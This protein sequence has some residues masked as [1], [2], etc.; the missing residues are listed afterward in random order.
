MHRKEFFDGLSKRLSLSK[1]QTALVLDN[2][3]EFIT[4][5]LCNDD[6]INFSAFGKFMNVHKPFKLGRSPKT[7][8]PFKIPAKAVPVF[9]PSLALKERIKK[10]VPAK[11]SFSC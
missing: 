8:E 3:F 4:E 9:K 11:N 10:N 7:G 5:V 6:E 2:I 1:K